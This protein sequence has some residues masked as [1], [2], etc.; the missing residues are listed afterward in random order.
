[1]WM[2]LWTSGTLDLPRLSKCVASE[3]TIGTR[4]GVKI[5][6]RTDCYLHQIERPFAGICAHQHKLHFSCRGWPPYI[7]MNTSNN[8]PPLF[9][10]TPCFVVSVTEGKELRFAFSL[11]IIVASAALRA[12]CGVVDGTNHH[13]GWATSSYQTFSLSVGMH[14]TAV[15]E[16]SCLDDVDG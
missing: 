12:A 15:V 11:R 14:G 1:M 6:S 16:L 4:L 2:T 8:H 13:S 3:M 7:A 5:V 9:Y 10:N